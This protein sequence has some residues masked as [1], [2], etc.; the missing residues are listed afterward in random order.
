VVGWCSG[1]REAMTGRQW[2][3]V[4]L[5]DREG[6]K[7]APQHKKEDG[8]KP[9]WHVTERGIRQW[10]GDGVA[11]LRWMTHRQNIIMTHT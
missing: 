9:T 4:D 6:V 7:S 3:R 1:E 8:V 10:R 5:H 11:V 2:L